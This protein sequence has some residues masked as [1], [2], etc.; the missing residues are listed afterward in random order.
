MKRIFI[1]SFTS[2][3]ISLANAGGAGG[4]WGE[5]TNTKP[6]S[7][8]D[9]GDYTGGGGKFG[10]GGAGGNW[11][12]CKYTIEVYGKKFEG[13]SANEVC[14]SIPHELIVKPSYYPNYNYKSF[15]HRKLRFSSSYKNEGYCDFIYNHIFGLQVH[16]SVSIKTDCENH[17]KTDDEP[18]PN[19]DKDK[20]KD[21]DNKDDNK[22]CDAT[23]KCKAELEAIRQA[24]LNL[25]LDV[26]LSRLESQLNTIIELMQSQQ[27]VQVDLSNI[28]SKLSQIHQAILN[29]KYD[30]TELQAKINSIADE[31]KSSNQKLDTI[32]SLIK[33]N[34]TCNTEFN[35]KI[36]EWLDAQIEQPEAQQLEITEV[37]LN[38]IDRN[39]IS[40]DK[41]CPSNLQI[42]INY[43]GYSKNLSFDFAPICKALNL[44]KPVIIFAG[45]LSALFIL[46]G[47]RRARSND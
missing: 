24:I 34:Q 31:L 20:D 28:E 18:T 39:R 25:R 40:F 27:Q 38:G 3:L 5:P 36:C 7:T 42:P 46:L 14:Q 13:N 10:G 22:E 47:V 23:C 30:D 17:V 11:Q 45:S 4:S 35:R 41:T 26:D 19:E 33:Q 43:L 9:T 16:T 6:A 2:L 37:T 8:N 1:F 44:L 29:S 12:E 15:S 32:I 21:K